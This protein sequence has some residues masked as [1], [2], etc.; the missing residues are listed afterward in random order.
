MVVA[1]APKIE[2]VVA[3]VVISPPFTATSAVNVAAPVTPSVPL[4]SALFLIVVEPV[5]APIRIDVPAEPMVNDVGVASR[6]NEVAVEFRSAPFTLKSPPSVVSPV[7]IS[8]VTFAEVISASEIVRRPEKVFAPDTVWSVVL[9]T[10]EPGPAIDRT[11][12]AV[13]SAPPV[14]RP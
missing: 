2:A 7:T 8:D 12:L 14:P 11:E 1:F 10:N 4:T 6:L 3:M 13:P 9:V 5:E